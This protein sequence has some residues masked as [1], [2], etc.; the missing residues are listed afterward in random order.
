MR[1][2]ACY[3]CNI[4]IIKLTVI[5]IPFLIIIQE[6]GINILGVNTFEA[7]PDVNLRPSLSI[8]YKRILIEFTSFTSDHND[9]NLLTYELQATGLITDVKLTH[10]QPAG[11]LLFART[12]T[13]IC[14]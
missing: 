2:V 12:M 6:H 5:T 10:G 8:E 9:I 13:C 4:V 11:M 14:S 1:P 3:V 7:G